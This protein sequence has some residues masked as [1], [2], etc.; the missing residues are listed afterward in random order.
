MSSRPVIGVLGATGFIDSRIVEVFHLE[1]IARVPPV[2]RSTTLTS[3]RGMSELCDRAAGRSS[4][5]RCSA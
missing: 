1:G 5:H 3:R 2:V 4:K